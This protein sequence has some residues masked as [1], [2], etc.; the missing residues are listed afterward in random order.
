MAKVD[1]ETLIISQN[2]QL[3]SLF[4]QIKDTRQY[5]FMYLKRKDGQHILLTSNRGETP[6]ASWLTF[7]EIWSMVNDIDVIIIETNEL[8]TN[9]KRSTELIYMTHK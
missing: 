9:W 8:Q 4:D 6:D 7:A 5:Q 2:A 3:R 1:N